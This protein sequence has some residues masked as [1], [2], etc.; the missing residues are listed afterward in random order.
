MPVKKL[1]RSFAGGEI[2]PEL[3]G[4]LDLVKF[5][6]GVSEC[7]NL[8]PLPHGPLVRRPS[9]TFVAESPGGSPQN[10]VLYKL[11]LGGGIEVLL[12]VTIGSSTGYIY[13]VGKPLIKSGSRY[14]FPTGIQGSKAQ[15]RNAGRVL[16]PNEMLIVTGAGGPRLIQQ[17]SPDNFQSFPIDTTSPPGSPPSGVLT[18]VEH[19]Y[20]SN[21]D[22]KKEVEEGEEDQDYQLTYLFDTGETEPSSTITL[23]NNLNFNG[24]YNELTITESPVGLRGTNVYKKTGGVFAY[25]GQIRGSATTFKDDNIRGDTLKTPP[26]YSS[27]LNTGAGHYP[28]AVGFFEQRLWWGGTAKEPQNLYASRT[29]MYYN[30]S[31]S[32]PTIGSD[33]IEVRLDALDFGSIEHI[34]PLSDLAVLTDKGEWR[35]YATGSEGVTPTSITAK[36]QGYAGASPVPP[37]VTS[38]SILFVQAKNS[39]IR[40]LSFNRDS[41]SFQSIDLTI[42]APHLFVGHEVERIEL[43]KSP[44]QILWALRNDGKVLSMTYQ[45]DQEVFAWAHHDF[46]AFVHDICIVKEHSED[47]LYLLVQRLIDGAPRYY[48]ER[49]SAFSPSAIDALLPGPYHGQ[50]YLDCASS[51]DA[52][53]GQTVF[54]GLERFN[55]EGVGVK[56]DG[57]SL[58]IFLV[59]NGQ[60]ELDGPFER[61]IIGRP[62][63]SRMT[64]LPLALETAEASA[65]GA[66]KNITRAHIRLQGSQRVSAGPTAEGATD[67]RL[68]D[69][70]QDQTD[71]PALYTGEAAVNIRPTWNT[72]GQIT[73]LTTDVYPMNII[74]MTLEVA[75]GG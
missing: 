7:Y 71:P 41:D 15:R 42:M 63:A 17:V 18:N 23:H 29:G 75:P 70:P 56:A 16:A 11:E 60:I 34:I 31:K 46:G 9:T 69:E 8:I 61:V 47:I 54:T 5:Q 28:K 19:N 4:R 64:T 52:N 32:R 20:P 65:Q 72:D 59:E 22:R 12:E 27:D 3:H 57:Y 38:S 73:V 50:D 37:V 55:G 26:E 39:R 68:P 14:S 33:S 13:E 30:M 74:S 2:T 67:L 58:G 49:M 51:F 43:M 62:Y 36:T 10:N 44:Y 24:A 48:I 21:S 6:T 35:I 25:I 45:P 1:Y 66:M 53:P 40:E